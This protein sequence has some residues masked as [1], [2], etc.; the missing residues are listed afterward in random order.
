MPCL[1]PPCPGSP[2]ESRGRRRGLRQSVYQPLCNKLR[3]PLKYRAPK[4]GWQRRLYS[5]PIPHLEVCLCICVSISECLAETDKDC[6]S[7]LFSCHLS[8]KGGRGLAEID[9][10]PCISHTQSGR[11]WT[12]CFLSSQDG[13]TN[14]QMGVGVRG[15]VLYPAFFFH[16][17]KLSLSFITP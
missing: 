14:T 5:S 7:A 16:T 15:D 9:S 12:H 8:I 3:T 4:G 17:T 11:L 10:G 1:L 6:P 2:Q 13:N